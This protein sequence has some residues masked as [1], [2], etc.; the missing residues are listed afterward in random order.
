VVDVWD[1]DSLHQ[2][3]Q[4]YGKLRPDELAE[5]TVEVGNYYNKAY[6]GVENNMLTTILFLSKI[7]D[8]YYF[9]TKIDEKTF[10]KTKK[11][12]WSTNIKTRDVMIDDFNIFFDEG[13][14]TIRS[15]R[16]AS[17]MKTFVKKDNG[18]RE[19]ADGKHDD[20]LFG[21]FIA[22]QMRK[23]DRPKARVF[24]NKPF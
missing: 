15:R 17:E 11:L 4:Y 1:R 24:E 13:H 7:Y 12:G 6:T 3:A 23:F 8:N 22:I 18:K 10:K 9:E 2:V 20:A 14:L 19:H 16:T 21:G 5:L